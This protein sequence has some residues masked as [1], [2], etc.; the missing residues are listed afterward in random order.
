VCV[1]VCVCVCEWERER[2]RERES[3]SLSTTL[4]V[5]H[6]LRLCVRV[7]LRRILGCGKSC[8]NK[9]LHNSY[10]TPKLL[11]WSYLRR[12]GTH[13]KI[14]KFSA[15]DIIWHNIKIKDSK[16]KYFVSTILSYFY[17]FKIALLLQVC[18]IALHR[19]VIHK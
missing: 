1:C 18:S 10:S 3:K 14:E 7:D 2:E 9:E 5:D 11:A 6:R 16:V 8:K 19:E 17:D 4:I 13:A 15:K 12:N